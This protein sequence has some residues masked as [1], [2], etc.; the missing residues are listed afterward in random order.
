VRGQRGEIEQIDGRERMTFF[1]G[2]GKDGEG[3]KGEEPLFVGG[4][5]DSLQLY[6]SSSEMDYV[7]NTITR[8]RWRTIT[9]HAPE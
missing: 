3:G 4:G 9:R 5:I 7:A 6:A 2:R 8:I 1:E